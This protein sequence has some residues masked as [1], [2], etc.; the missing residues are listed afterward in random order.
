MKRTTTLIGVALLV[1]TLGACSADPAEP[2][3]SP[4]PTVSVEPI[5]ITIASLKGPTT[6]GLVH[7]MDE[8]AAGTADMDYQV[9]IEGSPDA[10]VPQIAQGNVDIAL[11][12]SNLAAVLYNRTVGTDAA[13]QVLAINTLGVIY[14]VESG[15]SIQSIADL[16]GRTVYSAGKGASP[17]YTLNYLLNQNGLEPGVDVT[18]EYLSEHA[19]VAARLATEPGAIGVLPQPFVTIVESQNPDLRTALDFTEEWD[20]VSTDSQLIT[21]VVVVRAAFA[22]E[23]PEAVAV[24][25]RD[26]EASMA[27]TNEHPDEAA[28]L[29]VDAGIVPSIEIAETAIPA[30]YITF[31]DGS[32][33]RTMLSGYLTVLYNADPNS[34]GGTLPGDDFYYGG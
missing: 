28:P 17:E 5:T 22:A 33:L 27:F 9:T 26:Y 29:I 7:L 14:V 4:D 18:V 15:D 23:N 32:D 16:E 34:V 19:E 13:I 2:T 1:A 20:A 3:A 25:L 8:A 30:C 6:M 10:I 31:I 24:F 21:G 11:I 12:P